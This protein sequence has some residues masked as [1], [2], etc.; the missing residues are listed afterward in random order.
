[1]K[2]EILTH[3]IEAA[4]LMDELSL[5]TQYFQDLGY[6]YCDALFGFAWGNGY[7]QGPSWQSVRL[8]LE[9]L[10]K[11]VQRVERTGFGQ[12]GANDLFLSIP[13]LALKFRFCNDSDIHMEYDE[14][15]E[16][17]EFFY[18]RWKS[19]SYTPAEWSYGQEGNSRKRLRIN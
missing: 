3:P 19:L 11:E 16:I 8:P 13:T 1:M 4:Q 15:S 7:Y 10:V 6:E 14:P 5:F 9:G 2:R 18:Q 17:T 12:L